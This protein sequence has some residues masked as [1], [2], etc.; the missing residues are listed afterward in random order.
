MLLHEIKEAVKKALAVNDLDAVASLALEDRRTLN[1]LMKFSYDKGSLE[2]WRA[3]RAMGVAARALLPRD[4]DFLRETTRRLLWSVTEESGCMGWSAP[5]M[6]GEIISTDPRRFGDLIPILVS[7]FEEEIFRAGVLY[8]LMKVAEA[9]PELPLA[10]KETVLEALSDENPLVRF[11]ALRVVKMTG[12]K[13]AREKVKNLAA[14]T[15]SAKIYDGKDFETVEIGSLAE[16]VGST[17]QG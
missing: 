9:A 10:Y 2:T 5:E 6:M 13:E 15:S 17:L 14:E 3:I 1:V 7:M 4:Y 8:V 16:E 12:M 11:Y